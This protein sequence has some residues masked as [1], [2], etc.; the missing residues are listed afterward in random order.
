MTIIV[1]VKMDG[2]GKAVIKTSMI[3]FLTHANMKELVM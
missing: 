3:V 1:P 2:K